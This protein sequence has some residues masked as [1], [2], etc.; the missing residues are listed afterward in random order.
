MKRKGSKRFRVEEKPADDIQKGYMTK[1]PDIATS[2]KRM[3]I[4]Q[5]LTSKLHTLTNVEQKFAAVLTPGRITGAKNNNIWDFK[6]ALL[7]HEM[8]LGSGTAS[9]TSSVM[10]SS[11][12]PTVEKLRHRCV[13]ESRDHL[14]QLCKDHDIIPPLMAWE[15]WQANSMLQEQLRRRSDHN[16]NSSSCYDMVTFES[17]SNKYSRKV[18]SPHH[19]ADDILPSDVKHVDRGLVQ[20]LQRGGIQDEKDAVEIALDL[21]IHS[22]KL[23]DRI[24]SYARSCIP[25]KDVVLRGNKKKQRKQLQQIHQ[26]SAA[27]DLEP[28]IVNHKHTYDVYLGCKSKHILKLNTSHYRKLRELFLLVNRS[29]DN[30][31][32]TA[33]CSNLSMDSSSNDLSSLTFGGAEG[34]DIGQDEVTRAF[35]AGLYSMLAR[36]NALLGHGMQCALPEHVFEILH[37][38]VQTNFECF[39]S[40][41]NCRYSSYCSAFPDT[42][43]IFGSKGSF[44]DFFPTAGSYE[45]NPPFIESIMAEAVNHAHSLLSATTDAIS[46]VFIVPGEEATLDTTYTVT[47]FTKSATTLTARA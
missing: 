47:I 12:Q 4:N 11:V 25:G 17:T 20:D 40:P 16:R 9:V 1:L 44:F 6:I 7:Q 42:D 23:I 26:A 46:F 39:A 38:H 3:R 30:C 31:T 36:Y 18:R 13:T 14:N 10:I 5:S 21:V 19:L 8:S 22:K 2:Q 29:T 35:H 33:A 45:V 37:D 27:V 43:A 41:L 28:T 34:T 15:R 24:Q 32:V